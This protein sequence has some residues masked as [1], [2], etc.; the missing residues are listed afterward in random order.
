M[1]YMENWFC[2]FNSV[3]IIINC[4][5]KTYYS[6][7]FSYL[8]CVSYLGRNN[9]NLGKNIAYSNNDKLQLIT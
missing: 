4:V 5:Y 7:F 9:Q 3:I 2:K 6:I 1:S 8:V